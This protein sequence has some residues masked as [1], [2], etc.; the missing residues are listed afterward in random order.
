MPKTKKTKRGGGR[1]YLTK[2][3]KRGSQ[4]SEEL[5]NTKEELEKTKKELEKTKEELKKTKEELET[6]KEEFENTKEELLNLTYE[7]E[8]ACNY[9]EIQV[10]D[11]IAKNANLL[12]E[13]L[14]LLANLAQFYEKIYVKK[15]EILE[16]IGPSA[17]EEVKT[18]L[19][20]LQDYITNN[21]KLLID[22]NLDSRLRLRE[23][24]SLY[25]ETNDNLNLSPEILNKT[26]NSIE[27]DFDS[28]PFK[29]AFTELSCEVNGEK[30]GIIG[31][32]NDKHLL[33][34]FGL[35]DN[36]TDKKY[37][38]RLNNGSIVET[39]L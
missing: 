24:K 20:N 37:L 31:Y 5:A 28:F 21:I 12:H 32:S 7:Y 4:K 1:S 18:S 2:I 26:K 27:K 30:G 17:V 29:P 11:E 9:Y 19:D 33:N 23:K 16:I 38:V 15:T 34:Y 8:R 13:N 35:A 3:F 39:N 22:K 6:T 25:S 10:M 36:E 14:K